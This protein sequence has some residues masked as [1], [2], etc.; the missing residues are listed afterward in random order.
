MESELKTSYVARLTLPAGKVRT[1]LLRVAR[2]YLSFD[3]VLI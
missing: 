1:G 3:I 2:D